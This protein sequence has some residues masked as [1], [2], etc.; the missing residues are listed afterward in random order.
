[1]HDAIDSVEELFPPL[2]TDIAK[3]LA[4][5]DELIEDHC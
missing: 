2:N 4:P 5:P 3:H 1:L